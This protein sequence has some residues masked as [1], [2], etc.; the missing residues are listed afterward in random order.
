MVFG[1]AASIVVNSISCVQHACHGLSAWHQ[2]A[3][4]S[5]LTQDTGSDQ[6]NYDFDNNLSQTVV[7]VGKPNL[8]AGTRTCHYDAFGLRG[9]DSNTP[10]IETPCIGASASVRPCHPRL[11][12]P[13]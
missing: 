4:H 10:G 13:I 5:S 3:P 1:H 6:Y 9:A 7:R 2:A 12:L 8:T 11:T